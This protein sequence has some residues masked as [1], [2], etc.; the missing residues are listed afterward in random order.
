[1][2]RPQ[3]PCHSGLMA[4]DDQERLEASVR[5]VLEAKLSER[6]AR[7]RGQDSDVPVKQPAPEPGKRAPFKKRM[8]A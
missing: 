4:D 3:Q 2:E 6:R 8:K 7:A 1:M 5:M